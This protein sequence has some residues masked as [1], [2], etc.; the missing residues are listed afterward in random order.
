[1]R[2]G[3]Q[4]GWRRGRQA[5]SQVGAEVASWAR[6]VSGTRAARPANRN[7]RTT[8]LRF[9]NRKFRLPVDSYIITQRDCRISIAALSGVHFVTDKLHIFTKIVKILNLET[10][11]SKSH[12]IVFSTKRV[13][14]KI[15][16]TYDYHHENR[17][18]LLYRLPSSKFQY[19]CFSNRFMN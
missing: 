7:R 5:F 15:Q 1:M 16:A 10:T 13:K 2:F 11:F 9:S 12:K 8:K 4:S 17:Q 19:L 18:K 14:H 6:N 3:S